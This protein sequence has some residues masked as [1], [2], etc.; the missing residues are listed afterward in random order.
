MAR[1]LRELRPGMEALDR[2]AA[3]ALSGSS[4]VA[5]YLR[6]IVNRMVPDAAIPVTVLSGAARGCRLVI[7]PREEKFYWTGVYEPHLQRAIRQLL[8][9]GQTFWDVGAHIG[10]FALIASRA[11]GASGQVRCFEP[12]D[13]NRERLGRTVALNGLTNVT[14]SDRAVGGESGHAR[15]YPHKRSQMW[16]LED[17][18]GQGGEGGVPVRVCSLD[19]LAGELG[20][21]HVVKVDVE[22]AE[23]EVL[24]GGVRLLRRAQPVMLVEISSEQVLTQARDELRFCTFRHLGANHWLVRPTSSV[25]LR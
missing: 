19:D 20:D 9:P 16:A 21:P 6:P 13:D 23:L 10:F 7:R 17:Y 24:R 14:I 18:H 5:R 15:L 25:D 1:L 2:V 22:G 12:M 8:R 4:P 3:A 11:V